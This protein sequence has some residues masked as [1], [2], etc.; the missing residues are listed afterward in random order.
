MIIRVIQLLVFKSHLY[1][2][3]IYTPIQH[4]SVSGKDYIVLD[5][6]YAT[7]IFRSQGKSTRITPSNEFDKSNDTPYYLISEG[8]Q[9]YFVTS[10]KDGDILKISIPEGTVVKVQGSE[11]SANHIMFPILKSKNRQ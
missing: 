3:E 11:I 9:S 8:K 10:S 5:D 2:G 4:F 7:R 1:R 6:G